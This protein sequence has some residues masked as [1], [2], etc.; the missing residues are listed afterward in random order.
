MEAVLE[1][2]KLMKE[3]L[4]GGYNVH[5]VPPPKMIGSQIGWSSTA[6]GRLLIT[7]GNER[8]PHNRWNER[9]R[10]ETSGESKGVIGKLST[11]ERF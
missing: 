10:E 4:N 1:G 5:P 11:D 9:E 6:C 2:D 3:V 7:V 8:P